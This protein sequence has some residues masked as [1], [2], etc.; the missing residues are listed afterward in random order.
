MD[1]ISELSDSGVPAWTQ[2]CQHAISTAFPLLLSEW[3]H[4]HE[5]CSAPLPPLLLSTGLCFGLTA[6]TSS[7]ALP[8]LAGNISAPPQRQYGEAVVLFPLL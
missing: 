4:H 6:N 5:H 3:Y 1:G 8:H 2:K 7:V